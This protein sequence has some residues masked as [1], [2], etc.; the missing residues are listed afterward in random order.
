MKHGIYGYLTEKDSAEFLPENEARLLSERNKRH[1]PGT[2][3][4]KQKTTLLVFILVGTTQEHGP[5]YL[6]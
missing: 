1:R 6:P 4:A 3:S 2:V 5:S